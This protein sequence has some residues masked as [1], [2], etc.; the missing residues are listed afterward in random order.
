MQQIFIMVNGEQQGPFTVDQLKGY[1]AMGHCKDTDLAWHEG[2]PEWKALKDFPEFAPRQ[3]RTPNYRGI[4]VR[5]LAP[6]K[7]KKSAAVFSAIGT[8]LALG[9]VGAG[10]YFGY[11]YWQDHKN[12]AAAADTATNTPQVPA[13]PTNVAELS[14]SYA[15]PPQG[16]NAA[17]F[18]QQGFD[19]MDIAD[20]D[21][22]SYSVPLLGRAAM[23]APSAIVPGG[24]KTALKSLL[25]RNEAALALFEKGAQ[26]S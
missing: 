9:A 20:A 1:I 11:K 12:K 3:H 4:P 6:K 15:E 5:N 8:I 7:K 14:Q 23:P 16:Q 13:G 22:T 17:T 10:S 25:D 18:F 21:K 2:L 26:C 19:A 24:V